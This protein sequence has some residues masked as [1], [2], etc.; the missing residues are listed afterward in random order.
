MNIVHFYELRDPS[1]ELGISHPMIRTTRYDWLRLAKAIM[2]D[3]QNDT[4]V[5]KYLKKIYEKRIP[6]NLLGLPT[7]GGKK[8]AEPEFNRT[9]S[10]GGQFHF[11][12]PGLE[13]KVIFGLGGRGGQA[14]L[15]DV[16]NSR[17]VAINSMHYN[18]G[19]NKYNVKKLLIDPIKN[20]RK[21]N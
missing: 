13:D 17:I 1:E 21:I 2:D 18:N 12:Y 7:K 16:E 20:G 5:G 19:R 15:I 9:K 4:C 6:K 11:D 8:Y 3:Y 10:Y 14:I